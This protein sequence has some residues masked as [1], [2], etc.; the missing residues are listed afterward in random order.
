MD[1]A[2]AIAGV[3]ISSLG[4]A[5]EGQLPDHLAHLVLDMPD[6]KQRVRGW[7]RW[8]GRSQ[9]STIVARVDGTAV[10]FCA[11]HP[12]RDEAAGAATGGVRGEISA[13]YVL[14]S[15]WRRGIGRLLCEQIVTDARTCGFAEVVLWVLESNERALGF[16]D[17][18]GF[19]PDGKTRM[20]LERSDES[21]L[22]LR[23]GRR[24]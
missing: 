15:H 12:V 18:L 13:I 7:K 24:T 20:F 14:P 23:Y 6:V 22:E 19:R 17:S 4:A 3:H 1:D 2:A 16:Y 11:L 8:L 5:Y 21:M 9:A 10:G